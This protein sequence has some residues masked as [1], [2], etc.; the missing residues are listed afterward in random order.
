MVT[1]AVMLKIYFELFFYPEPKGQLTRNSIGSIEVTCRSD[2]AKIVQIG[3]PRWP[4]S[5]KSILNF[6]N[7][8]ASW[9]KTCLVIRWAIQGHL[10]PLVSLPVRHLSVESLPLLTP[11]W[12][13][14]FRTFWELSVVSHL[15]RTIC[16]HCFDL[17]VIAVNMISSLLFTSHRSKYKHLSLSLSLSLC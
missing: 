2:G 9:F 15:L 12:E 3:N 10:G 16:I 7:P 1:L 11:R 13:L 4:P 5:W 6:L 14:Q 8:R 17:V